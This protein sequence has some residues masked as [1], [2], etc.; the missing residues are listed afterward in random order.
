LDSFFRRGCRLSS[1]RHHA[2]PPHHP[3]WLLLGLGF[4]SPV[5]TVAGG[6]FSPW[7]SKLS[8]P[9]SHSSHFVPEKTT[10]LFFS[11]LLS[12]SSFMC[13]YCTCGPIKM[14]HM[15]APSTLHLIFFLFFSNF[16]NS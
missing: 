1:L 3:S 10:F 2:R 11:F 12:C 4:S 13:T 16:K 7:L 15:A 6:R 5:A 14:Q 9:H 8:V